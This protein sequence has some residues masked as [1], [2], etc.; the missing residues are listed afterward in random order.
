M[1]PIP[2][3]INQNPVVLGKV[4]DGSMGSIAIDQAMLT[5]WYGELGLRFNAL[6]E[7]YNC[8]RSQVND[9]KAADTCK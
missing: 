3:N 6:R 2:N 7:Y 4:A 1:P 5:K 9:H 8:V